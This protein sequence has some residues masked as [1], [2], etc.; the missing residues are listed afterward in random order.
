MMYKK[1][2]LILL[3][4]FLSNFILV[5]NNFSEQSVAEANNTVFKSF[6]P[7]ILLSTN[8]TLYPQ[9]VEP[10]LAIGSNDELYVGWKNALGPS[11]AGVDVSFTKS[12]DAGLNWT[13]SVSMPSNVSQVGSKSDPWMNVYNHTIY[14]SYLEFNDSNIPNKFSQ[15]TMARSTDNGKTWLTSRASENTYFADKETFIVSPNGTIYLA[16]DDVNSDIG[17]FEVKLVHSI[18]SG[19]SFT[20]LSRIDDLASNP[21]LGPYLALSQ[22]QTLYATW[23]MINRTNQKGDVYYDYSSNGGKSF[24]EDIDLNPESSYGS[25]FGI[26]TPGKSTIPVMK[27]DSLGRLYILWAEFSKQWR[28]YLKYSDDYGLNWSPKIPIHDKNNVY[29]WE[30]DMAIDSN[31]TLHVVWYEQF[32]NQYRPYYRT[33]SFSGVNRS[34]PVYSDIIPVADKLTPSRFVRPGDYCTIR[35]DSNNTPNIVWTDGRS[36]KLDIYYAKASTEPVKAGNNVSGFLGTY[37]PIIFVIYLQIIKK[38]NKRT[39]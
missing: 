33:I 22:N 35:I 28:V 36:D 7:N 9:H 32:S 15:V 31:N 38:K 3:I 5:G 16:Y 20:E 4:C 10:T 8:D 21:V 23:F 24:G 39:D 30:P 13:E 6:Y 34:D 18:D 29:Q 11:S 1:A 27:F 25:A 12:L 26:N 17:V 2:C 19:N 14:Y 37:I